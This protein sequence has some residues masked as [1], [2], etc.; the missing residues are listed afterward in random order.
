MEI[1]QIEDQ[2]DDKHGIDGGRNVISK[3][4]GLRCG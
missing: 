3:S 1:M 4:G 2:R